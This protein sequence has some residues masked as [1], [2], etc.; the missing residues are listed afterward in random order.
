MLRLNSRPQRGNTLVELLTA[1]A[2]LALLMTMFVAVFTPLLR[3]QKQS[4]AKL[5]TVQSAA[6]ALYRVQRDL[7]QTYYKSVYACTSSGSPSCVPAYT[8]SSFSN[9]YTAIA[10]PSAYANGTGAF[11]IAGG[12]ST[13]YPNWVGMTVYWIDSSGALHW[14]FD[15][16]LSG[17]P[18]GGGS[19]GTSSTVASQAVSDAIN[20]NVHSTQIAVNVQQLSVAYL[21]TA[22]I[23]SLQMQAQ[24]T[25]NGN[26]NETTYRSDVLARQ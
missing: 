5:D 7:R 22:N 24:S 15:S 21:G 11:Q 25:E 1:T 8:V 13:G 26:T 4:Q 18:Q 20:G 19:P 6:A 9:T 23:I 12:S 14:A 2:V 16:N 17:F 3:S 10:M